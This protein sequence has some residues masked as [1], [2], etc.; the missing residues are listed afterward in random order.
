M[1]GGKAVIL[2]SQAD[3]LDLIMNE[4]EVLLK[5]HKFF[6]LQHLN[7]QS[8]VRLFTDAHSTLLPYK[9]LAPFQRFTLDLG[10]FV[11]HPDLVGQLSDGET[12]FAVETKGDT[13]LLR[14]LAQ[15]EMYQVGF[16]YT[17][18]AADAKALGT[19]LVDFA[20][21]KNVGIVAV[22]DSVTIGHLPEVHM[23]L[24]NAFKFILRQMESVIQVSR[25]QTF[26]FNIPTHYL[27]WA[28]VLKLNINYPMEALPS[29][30][31][32]YPIPE[33][34]R[35]TLRGAQKLGLVRILGDKV[36]LTPVGQ[37][38]KDILQTSVTEWAEVHEK[39]GARGSGIPLVQ[40][41]PQYAAVLRL[42]LLQDPI[43]RLIIEGLRTF[44]NGLANF[45]ELS[46]ACD[47]LDHAR[48][49]VLFLKPEAAV[50]LTDSKGKVDWKSAKGEY[51]R[52]TTFYQ[53]KSILKHAGILKAT[54]L[55]GAT[56]V[57]YDPSQDIWELM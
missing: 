18:L 43:T 1:S 3:I 34:W 53:Y 47:Q 10:D 41:K 20:R 55:G 48:T 24:R 11:M 7:N 4:Q 28:I 17:F 35:G 2:L 37:A 44:P 21:R 54:K 8:V 15:A 57:G 26:E 39:V 49:P 38:V 32:G 40:Y 36:Q 45:A 25:G 13:D 12:I 14:G 50:L 27:V 30:L 56:T 22:S 5:T 31:V 23:P 16:H 51:Y 46:V 42:L 9:E 29:E 33:G 19:S 52:S 6:K